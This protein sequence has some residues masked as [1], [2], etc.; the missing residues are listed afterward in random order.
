M[1][2]PNAES[3]Y[4]GFGGMKIILSVFECNPFRGSDSYVGWSYT[5]NM[6][7]YHEVFALTRA[8][9]RADIERYFSENTDSVQNR[10]HF[11]YIPRAKFFSEYVYR[12]NRYAGFL[13]SYFMWQSAALKTAKKICCEHDI[14]LCHHVSI[15]DFRCAGY[16]W[17][18]GKPFVYGPVGG[19]QEIPGCLTPYSRGHEKSERFRSVMNRLCPSFPG[20]RRALR[21]AAKVYSSNDE[22]TACLS[23]RMRPADRNKLVQMTELCVDEEYICQR[24]MLQKAPGDRVHI[25]VSGRLIYR[26]GVSLLLD[27][28]RRIQTEQPFVVDI[29]GEGDQKDKLLEQAQKNGIS[30]LV[31]FHGKVSFEEMQ[32]RYRE[33][34]IYVLPSLRETTGTAVFEAM[35]NKLPVVS[36][37]QNGVKHIVEPDMGILV[38]IKSMEQVLD[39]LAN[40]LKRLIED[41]KLRQDMGQAGYCKI[42]E[43]FTWSERARTM[44]SVYEQICLKERSS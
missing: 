33:A 3:A 32:A 12:L 25:I 37:K 29:Y 43:Q 41:T 9:N 7:R 1:D 19:A 44:S 40:A 31:K 42:R 35:A 38:D 8:E 10:V 5:V 28:V 15:A 21:H 17:K 13:G 11:V 16:L 27:A 20:Y 30:G 18:T 24:D 22:T 14:A 39:D 23:A 26:K 34:D 2:F 4:M 6:A 36:L